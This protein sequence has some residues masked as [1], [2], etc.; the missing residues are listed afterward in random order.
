MRKSQITGNKSNLGD[1]RRHAN[2]H[3]KEVTKRGQM[4]QGI[5]LKPSQALCTRSM[6]FKDVFNG[7]VL[8]DMCVLKLPVWKFPKGYGAMPLSTAK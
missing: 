6:V 8:F 7:V 2:C 4:R 1:A 5:F 3:N